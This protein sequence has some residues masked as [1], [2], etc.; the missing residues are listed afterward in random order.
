LSLFWTIPIKPTL[1]HPISW[2]YILILSVFRCSSRRTGSVCVRGSLAVDM[3]ETE[4]HR[5]ALKSASHQRVLSLRF[6]KTACRHGG[7]L[8]IYC[9]GSLGQPIR[10][11]STDLWLG[12]QLEIPRGNN[13]NFPHS[14]PHFVVLIVLN[15]PPPPAGPPT[16]LRVLHSDGRSTN[17]VSSLRISGTW[18]HF[19]IHFRYVLL[20]L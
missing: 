14:T 2:R 6:K 5:P 15:L 19:P 4:I 10:G 20:T 18:L 13:Q 8:A 7:Y 1:T 11:S 9:I 17:L 16:P 3:F 12:Q